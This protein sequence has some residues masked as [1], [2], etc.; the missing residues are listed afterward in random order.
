MATQV[1][2]IQKPENVEAVANSFVKDLIAKG[3]LEDVPVHVI[4]SRECEIAYAHDVH[5]YLSTL[6]SQEDAVIRYETDE[7]DTDIDLNAAPEEPEAVDLDL[8]APEKLVLAR[9]V[10][11][12]WQYVA[13]L[14][15]TGRVLF[16]TDSRLARVFKSEDAVITTIFQ[17]KG[18]PDDMMTLREMFKDLNLEMRPA[19][20]P[21]K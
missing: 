17:F 1:K 9:R 5:A 13:G 6:P 3:L 20:K 16:T 7:I 19:P 11:Y 21:W 15:R 12:H 2:T 4:G 8:D 10:R 14:S 18:E